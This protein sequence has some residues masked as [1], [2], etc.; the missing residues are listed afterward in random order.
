MSNCV[1]NSNSPIVDGDVVL[2]SASDFPKL[3]ADLKNGD[4]KDIGDYA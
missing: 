2:F 4:H 3:Q 1:I